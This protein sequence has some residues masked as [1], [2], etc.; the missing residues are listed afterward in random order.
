MSRSLAI[1]GATGTIG[2]NALN[3]VDQHPE[4]FHVSV[5]S[6]H[7][8][9]EKL[10]VLARQYAPDI[11]VIGTPDGR[12]DLLQKLPDFK[13][14]IL[15]GEA[16]LLQAARYKVDVAVM[17]IVGFAGLAP[18]MVCAEQGS[19]L[20]LANKEALVAAGPLLM[21]T[22]GQNK[23]QILPVDSEHNAIYQL[24]QLQTEETSHKSIEKIVL[25]A[26]GGPFRQHTLAEM[27]TVTPAQA[28]AHP[29]WD[30][31]AKI[32]VDSA[33]L[34][35]KG[36]ELIEARYLFDIEPARLDVLVHPQSIVHGLVYFNDGSVLAQKGCPDMRV[37]LA[38]CMAYP[39]RIA[40]GVATL[41]LA[42]QGRLDFEAA[43]RERFACLALAEAAM[44][45]DGDAPCVLNAA[46]EMAVA[47]F[48]DGQI[49][50]TDIGDVVDAVL[51]DHD[52]GGVDSLEAI[53]ATDA[54][55]RQVAEQKIK[56]VR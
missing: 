4:R 26:S 19:M 8:N 53:V 18:S 37:P 36:L 55:A 52:V 31:G 33:T 27:A 6:A 16:G 11:L 5:L 51:Q 28:V 13:G 14:D 34:M 7:R 47:A 32:S 9:T 45:A 46:N 44:Q 39:E 21:R 23:T 56:R 38:Y 2:D 54:R 35:N 42:A 1:F 48:L 50:F 30:M 20:A 40:S 25:T 29:N 12:K 10:A 17:A 15:I 43:D 3:L 24:L 22:A 49:G 41:D